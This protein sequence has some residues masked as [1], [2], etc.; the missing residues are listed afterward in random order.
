MAEKNVM[1][2]QA[3]VAPVPKSSSSTAGW[4]ANSNAQLQEQLAKICDAYAPNLKQIS[5]PA[6]ASRTLKVPVFFFS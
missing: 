5:Y 6:P 2:F 1:P 3:G 4:K